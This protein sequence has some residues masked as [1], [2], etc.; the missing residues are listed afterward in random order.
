MMG[1]AGRGIVWLVGV[2][3]IDLLL[4]YPLASMSVPPLL[5]GRLMRYWSM[6]GRKMGFVPIKIV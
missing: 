5:P 2:L 6:S 3:Y 1:Q 4:C